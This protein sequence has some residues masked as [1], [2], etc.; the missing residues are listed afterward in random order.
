MTL[1][2]DVKL[3]VALPQIF[4]DGI[5]TD[6]VRDFA[7]IAEDAGFHSLWTQEQVL[8]SANVLEPLSL[9][10]YT[11]AETSSIY[12]GVSILVLPLRNPITLAKQAATLD[13]LSRGRF[14]LGIGIG[15][16]SPLY[17]ATGTP[18]DARVRRFQESMA[19]MKALWTKPATTFEGRFFKLKDAT[20][21]PKPVQKPHPP[22]WFGGR[23]P[24]AL[25]RAVRHGNGWMGAGSSTLEDFKL[26]VAEIQALLQAAGID[27]T[28]FGISKRVYL[29]VD[30][31]RSRAE[32]RL[33]SWFGYYYR[34]ADMA[35]RVCIWGS[36]SY[37]RERLEEIAE[38]GADHLLLNPVYDH[39][40][41]LE[42]FA[43]LR[44][45]H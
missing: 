28:S 8:G 25:M 43:R 13:Q 3:G 32:Q 41:H 34:N 33:R 7:G 6:L 27:P 35:N 16:L 22:I 12:L 37:I 38:A 45:A 26:S 29:A 4:P 14:I 5:D 10:S 18:E 9:L 42:K 11:A 39:L 20:M 31:D 2:K 30:D 36:Q 1:G 21:E 15:N 44:D 19:V 17:A 24:D 40:E 23:H